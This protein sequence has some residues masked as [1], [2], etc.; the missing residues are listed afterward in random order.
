MMKK[1]SK[2]MQ[3]LNHGKRINYGPEDE[4]GMEMGSW[5]F[6]MNRVGGN[7]ECGRNSGVFSLS[8]ITGLNY[9]LYPV[10]PTG[11][12]PRNFYPHY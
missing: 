2:K 3:H 5:A 1:R 4:D 7:F 12:R 10:S 8:R 6:S 11:P 9:N